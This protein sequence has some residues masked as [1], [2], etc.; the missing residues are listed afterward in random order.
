MLRN[1]GMQILCGGILLIMIAS[2]ALLLSGADT[3]AWAVSTLGTMLWMLVVLTYIAVW[4]SKK[5]WPDAT[6]GE[7]VFN[8]MTFTR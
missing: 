4:D 8:L 1:R 6:L 7:R 2:I 5:R 3:A